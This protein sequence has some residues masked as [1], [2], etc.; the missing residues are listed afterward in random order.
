MEL[1]DLNDLD[2]I[3]LTIEEEDGTETECQMICLFEYNDRAFA[4]LTPVDEAINE[5]YLFAAIVDQQGDEIEFTIENINDDELMEEVSQVF[6]SI[7]EQA[8]E[9]EDDDED[10]D[11]PDITEDLK[12]I[13]IEP[14]VNNGESHERTIVGNDDEAYWDQFIN[15]KLE[16]L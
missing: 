6:T 16:D 7:M 4:A 1:P 14:T 10:E 12:G 15:K 13:S 9:A 2:D 3:F 8:A 11:I 5:A